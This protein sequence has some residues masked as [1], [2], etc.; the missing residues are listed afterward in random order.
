M[1][2]PITV[3]MVEDNQLLRETMAM[4][5]EDAGFQVIEAAQGEAAVDLV[6]QGEAIDVLFTDIRLP[7]R[8]DGWE[9]AQR[10]RDAYPAKPIIYA[11]AYAPGNE[12]RVSDSLFFPKPYRPSQIVDAIQRLAGAAG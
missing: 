3:L 2:R 6:A 8:F 12:R 7:G 4:E 1:A 10:F 5:L 11:S 9:V